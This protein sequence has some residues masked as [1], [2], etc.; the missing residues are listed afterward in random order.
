MD[1]NQ[2]NKSSFPLKCAVV[3]VVTVPL[4]QQMLDFTARVLFHD[5]DYHGDDKIIW[6]CVG[7]VITIIYSVF[8][9][10]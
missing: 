8:K 6:A 5:K 4:L 2:N 1:E 10:K 3:L 7:A 9:K